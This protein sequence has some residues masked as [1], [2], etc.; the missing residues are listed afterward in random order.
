MSDDVVDG[1]TDILVS[2]A[3]KRRDIWPSKEEAYQ[4]LKSRGTW[5]S[6]DDR[7]LRSYVVS[8]TFGFAGPVLIFEI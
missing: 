2:G 3:E 1:A 7:V 4:A 5:K 6:W 8:D